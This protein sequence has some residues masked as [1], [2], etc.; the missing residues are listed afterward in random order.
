MF[1]S[2]A[3]MPRARP[4]AFE[5]R[6]E[7]TTTLAE[8]VEAMLV[9]ENWRTFTGW[10]PLPGIRS[11]EIVREV[12]GFVG[13]EFRVTNTDGSQHTET[14]VAWE[15]AKVLQ[16]EMRDLPRPLRWFA[17]HLIEQW[18]LEGS[19]ST[20]QPHTLIRSMKLYPASWLGRIILLPIRFMMKKAIDRHTGQVLS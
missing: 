10:G 15:D 20:V 4:L 2:L 19:P 1:S 8:I 5:R 12:E 3:A 17:T 7:T 16:I 9:P 11:V 13:T 14:I 6:C 18:T